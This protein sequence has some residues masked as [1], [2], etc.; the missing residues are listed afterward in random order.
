MPLRRTHTVLQH[1]Q[2]LLGELLGGRSLG[3]AL[4]SAA[5]PIFEATL[6]F[7]LFGFA[8]SPAAPSSVEA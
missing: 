3:L 6:K 4:A 2:R 1:P 7:L 8:L 5:G